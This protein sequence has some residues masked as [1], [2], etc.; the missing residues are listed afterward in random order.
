[1]VAL[2][3]ALD[4]PPTDREGWRQ[5]GTSYDELTAAIDDGVADITGRSD[6]D[7]RL[8]RF[9]LL[10]G[11]A[12]DDGAAGQLLVADNRAVEAAAVGRDLLLALDQP[13][14]VVPQPAD[15]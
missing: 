3:A 6:L 15:V 7:R 2:V 11:I 14:C 10:T 12:V 1:M 9:L 8:D 4:R 13:G 5:V